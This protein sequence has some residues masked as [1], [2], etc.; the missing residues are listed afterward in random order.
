MAKSTT[1]PTKS[2]PKLN[3]QVAKDEAPIGDVDADRRSFL[4]NTTTAL[5]LAGAA[6]VA[7]P[8]VQSMN[9]NRAVQ[10]MATLDVNLAEIPEGDF[11]T[12]LWQGKPV[13]IWHRS[14][15]QVTKAAE[16]DATA[17]IQPEADALRVQKPNWLVV[18]GI[19][20]HLGCVP[21]KGTDGWRCPCHGSQFDLSGRVV[22]GPAGKNLEIPPYRFLND[23]TI[24]I[25]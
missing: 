2:A 14:A 1:K 11:K 23:T 16:Q 17:T 13:F 5:G 15:Q 20:S 19:C 3:S 8:F 24:R 6:C 25:G 12:Y 10:A 7:L 9:P 22:K 21:M 18:M 4:I